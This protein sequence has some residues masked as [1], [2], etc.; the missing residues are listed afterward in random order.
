MKIFYLANIRLPTEKAHGIQIMNMCAAFAVCGVEVV[1]IVPR[2][3]N[4][5]K[6]NPF[7][8]YTIK[9]S[10]TIIYLP[11]LDL[12]PFEKWLGRAA[13]YIQ[14]LSFLMVCRVYALFKNYDYIYTRDLW[15]TSLFTSVILELHTIS[16]R[17]KKMLSLWK[18]H[19]SKC[20]VLTQAMARDLE[21]I[22]FLPSQ[23]KVAPDGVDLP[24]F[25]VGETKT[26]A[27]E[28]VG[29]PNDK[30]LLGYVG[31]LRT[32]GVEKGLSILVQALVGLSEQ[33][34][35]VV[36]GGHNDDIFAYQTLA[37]SL[38]V[39]DRVFFVGQVPH[40][41]IPVYLRSFDMV[42]APF[43]PTEHYMHYMSPLKLFEYMASGKPIIA[44]DLPSMREVLNEEGAFWVKEHNADVWREKI[45]YV[46]L[47]T[48]EAE[49]KAVISYEGV[50][51]LQWQD[52][53]ER[54]IDFL[55]KR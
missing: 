13:F 26:G 20:I 14:S 16:G 3:K 9:P 35:L 42:A 52:R 38:G 49:Q 28:K 22:G 40:A 31:M 34:C 44:S 8:F 41:M 45:A 6:D 53:A 11:C 50:K 4:S 25:Q 55:Q 47:H 19:L 36:V 18:K 54:I 43:P 30:I 12:I 51:K 2:R 32:M 24:R 5:I 29:L 21:H 1:L 27:R 33:V 46:L 37:C 7:H 10:F 23:I 39:E 15:V 17:I 48:A